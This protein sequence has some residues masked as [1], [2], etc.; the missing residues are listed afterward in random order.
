MALNAQLLL[1]CINSQAQ[2]SIGDILVANEDGHLLDDAAARMALLVWG[3]SAGDIVEVD[4]G[5]VERLILLT[6]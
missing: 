2:G 4:G 3:A 6:D 5:G 1:A